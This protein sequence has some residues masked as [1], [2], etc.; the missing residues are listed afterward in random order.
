MF[1]S[2]RNIE[3]IGELMEELKHYVG[4]QGEY[5]KLDVVDKVVRLI[6]ALI[7]GVI[8]LGLL[9]AALIYLS[10]AAALALQ[11]VVG[12]SCAFL[13]IAALYLFVL[14]LFII[15]RHQWIERPLVRLLA[16]ILM[17]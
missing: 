12:A 4:L 6:T 14:L 15:F 8:L 13:I 11:P 10:F 2:D 17:H 16:G 5:L 1:S 3:T 7:M 9:G